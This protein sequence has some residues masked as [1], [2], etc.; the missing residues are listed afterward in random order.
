MHAL[1]EL[2]LVD[3]QIAH[4]TFF[5]GHPETFLSVATEAYLGGNLRRRL[6]RGTPAGRDRQGDGERNEPHRAPRNPHGVP[7][8]ASFD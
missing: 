3:V 1:Q 7:F 6:L 5:V 2:V 8:L 4:I